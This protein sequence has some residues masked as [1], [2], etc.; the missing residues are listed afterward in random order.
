MPQVGSGMAVGD[1]AA[2]QI[3]GLLTASHLAVPDDVPLLIVEHAKD[4]GATDAGLYL[5]D[6]DQRTL[7]PVPHP[8]GEGREG[9]L[10]DTTLAGRCYR[11]LDMQQTTGERGE[12]RVWVPV[13]DGVERIGVLEFDFDEQDDINLDNLAAFAGLVAELV[14]AK[15]AYGDL[16]ERVRR[17]KQMSVAAEL[18]W[19]L[20]PPLTFGTTVWSSAEWS[21]RL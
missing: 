2:Q 18:A 21:P 17:S 13:L 7:M 10:I 20:L 8:K 15:Q 4:L 19:N 11:T 3:I 16:F 9:V 6:Y 5:V 14:M 1:R 12:V